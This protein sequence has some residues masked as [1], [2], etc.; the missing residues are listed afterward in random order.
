MGL[1]PDQQA[2]K[3]SSVL[4][5]ST[6]RR[7]KRREGSVEDVSQWFLILWP[8]NGWV[9][10]GVRVE[11]GVEEEGWRQTGVSGWGWG[12]VENDLAISLNR[13]TVTLTSNPVWS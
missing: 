2:D 7:Y 4:V 8:W 11:G 1:G 3:E 10:W 12:G 9:G 5:I 6:Q 13:T